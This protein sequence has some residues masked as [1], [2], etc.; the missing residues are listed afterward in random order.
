VEGEKLGLATR[1]AGEGDLVEEETAGEGEREGGEEGGGEAEEEAA[2]GDVDV[3]REE[4]VEARAEADGEVEV[5][6]EAAEEDDMGDDDEGEVVVFTLLM[7]IWRACAPLSVVAG[8]DDTP[9]RSV[10]GV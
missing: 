10:A 1:R 5:E 9:C 2:E 7:A 3:E 6:G 8:G 4:V